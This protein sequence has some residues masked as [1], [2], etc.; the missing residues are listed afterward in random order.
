VSITP[1]AGAFSH[2]MVG[3]A[4]MHCCHVHA[5]PSERMLPLPVDLVV[6]SA[7]GR[8]ATECA[9]GCKSVAAGDDDPMCCVVRWW[10]NLRD[11]KTDVGG[12]L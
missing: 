9:E 2:E 11:G 12:C 8:M 1:T 5:V 6:A 7:G 3:L 10:R 4:D